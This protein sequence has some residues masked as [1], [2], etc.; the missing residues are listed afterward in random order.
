MR[1][2]KMLMVFLLLGVFICCAHTDARAGLSEAAAYLEIIQNPDGS[3]GSDPA[4]IYFETTEVVKTLYSLGRTGNAYQRGVNFVTN[5]QIGGVEDH[6]RK[7][8]AIKPAGKDTTDDM[9][10]I[11]GAQN[12]DGGFGSNCNIK[13]SQLY[14]IPARSKWLIWFERRS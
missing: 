2:N 10:T 12:S 6:A 13:R 9:N 4:T 14:H 8:D 7:I 1:K 5:H 3:W 11:L